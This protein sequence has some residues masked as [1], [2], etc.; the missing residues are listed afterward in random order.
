MILIE[1]KKNKHFGGLS[2]V[3]IPVSYNSEINTAI[4]SCNEYYFDKKN[5]QWEVPTSKLSEILDSLTSFD[6]ICIKLLQTEE[7]PRDLRDLSLSYKLPP[8]KHQEEAI[9]FGLNKDKWLLLDEIGLGKTKSVIHIAEELK[10]QGLIEHCFIICGINSLKRNW[11]NEIAIH[12]NASAVILGEQFYKK[13]TK[14]GK[15]MRT[16]ASVAK[17]TQQLLDP[18]DSLFI[19]ANAENFRDDNFVKAFKTTK[20]KIDMIVIDEVHKVQNPTSTTGK[21]I[22]KTESK[23]KIAIT[24]TLLLNRPTDA[25]MALKWIGEEAANFTDF[26]RYYCEFSPYIK[27]AITGYKNIDVLKE[28]LRTCSLRRKK[29]ILNLP[30]QTFIDEFID[31]NDDQAKFYEDIVAGVKT[32]VDKVNL[33]TSNLLAMITR[34]R[35]ATA[36]PS[37]LTSADIKSSKLER[38][39]DLI[40][41]IVSNKE[42]V[43]VMSTYKESIAVLAEQLKDHK[44]LVCTGDV[45]DFDIDENKKTFQTNPEY[46]IMLCTWQK[47]GTGHTLTAARY[48]IH[49]DTAYT[50]SIFDQ[51]SGRIHRIGTKEPVFIINLICNDTVDER[52]S[53]IL[54]TK[55]AISDFIIDDKIIDNNSLNILRDFITNL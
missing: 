37:I 52:V 32:E 26:K 24:G 45:S 1:E 31:M 34:L 41:E 12:S 27:G 20:N 19:I 2:S 39:K 33:T 47:M 49:L 3:Y 18:I 8:F 15:P 17:R 7:L 43:V 10:A 14:E 13:G 9:R 40:E 6:D 22:L 50:W 29:D 30:E 21:N 55:K 4:K 11:K 16:Y 25:F 35:Q 23:Y 38:A 48:M 28:H 44:V 5:M 42:K 46:K 54:K 51:T 36:C 53:Y